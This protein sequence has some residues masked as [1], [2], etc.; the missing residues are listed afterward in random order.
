MGS[1]A[2]KDR[3]VNTLLFFKQCNPKVQEILPL[4]AH[5]RDRCHFL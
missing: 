5:D 3:L 2:F 1:M 4:K